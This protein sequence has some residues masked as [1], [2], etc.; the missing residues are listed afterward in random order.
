MFLIIGTV[1]TQKTANF[2]EHFGLIVSVCHRL[3]KKRKEQNAQP[4]GCAQDDMNEKHFLYFQEV[5]QTRSIQTAADNLYISR[6]GVSKVIRAMEEELHQTLFERTADGL[7]P[8]DFAVNLLPHVQRILAEYREISGLHTLTG[9]RKAVVTVYAFANF[10]SYLGYSFVEAFCRENPDITLSFMDST[11][12]SAYEKLESHICDFAI[13]GGQLDQTRFRGERLFF[14]RYCVR[15]HKDHPCAKKEF[16]TP[17]D[18]A[19]MRVA[20]VGRAFRAFRET[21]DHYVFLKGKTMEIPVETPDN[22]MLNEIAASGLAC[23]AT[24]DYMAFIE[25]REDVVVRY[26]ADPN[27][28]QYLYLVENNGTLPTRAARIFKQFLL[29]WLHTHPDTRPDP[30]RDMVV[31]EAEAR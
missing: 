15:M 29:N 6:Q 24:Y 14:S 17:E 25:P 20:G 28:G 12:E 3:D 18:F 8:T 21:V 19:G 4:F 16:V 26:Y 11:D 10:L 5:F 9:Q 1:E 31:D 30:Y 2:T 13:V 7:V 27:M 23:V 22:R